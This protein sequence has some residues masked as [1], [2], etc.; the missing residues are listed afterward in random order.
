[1]YREA[2]EPDGQEG[3]GGGFGWI[4]GG[5]VTL[6]RGGHGERNVHESLWFY[7]TFSII[8]RNSEKEGKDGRRLLKV[9]G[10][11]LTL[12]HHYNQMT[13]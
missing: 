6:C 7:C 9:S 11:V 1:M 8:L 4:N 10:T 2:V 13:I 5:S 12:H 3:T